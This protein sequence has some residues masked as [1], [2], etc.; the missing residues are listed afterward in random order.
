MTDGLTKIV[1]I[2]DGPS[3]KNAKNNLLTPVWKVMILRFIHD[4]IDADK[5]VD[6]IYGSDIIVRCRRYHQQSYHLHPR[7][8]SKDSDCY[9]R[10]LLEV[11]SA[12]SHKL[13][14][15][16]L[17]LQLLQMSI[18]ESKHSSDD[19]S[20]MA[21]YTSQG[22]WAGDAPNLDFITINGTIDIPARFAEVL[23]ERVFEFKD[24]EIGYQLIFFKDGLIM[25]R[26]DSIEAKRQKVMSD[27][28]QISHKQDNTTKPEDFQKEL[29]NKAEKIVE[30]LKEYLQILNCIYL[31][32]D[33]STLTIIR[34]NWFQVNE[35]T[36]RDAFSV[37]CMNGQMICQLSEG[38]N[39]N[40]FQL[41]RN[42]SSYQGMPVYVDETTK[43]V[44]ILDQRL[45]NRICLPKDVFSTVNTQLR[46]LLK[47]R[48]GNASSLNGIR[49]LSDI[50]KSIHEYKIGNY[51][52]SLVLAWFNIEIFISHKWRELLRS[53]NKSRT[54]E[55]KI[56]QSR[57]K[58]FDG[59]DYTINTVLNIFEHIIL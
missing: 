59:R 8:A 17:S 50:T 54:D 13:I 44:R 11:A 56:T 49:M 6:D 43:V 48:I 16:T 46:L 5:Y 7:G 55:T 29:D 26:L 32:L 53:K 3:S 18:F 51:S 10:K 31:L 30:F 15:Y 47:D 38:L 58:E 25:F 35:L 24:S 33:S 40:S 20:F 23:S 2:M 27:A 45:I 39:Q 42:F 28:H 22:F 21:F 1:D 52:T 36:N 14:N 12:D 19:Q 41:G 34:N 57:L 4:Y 9:V 37:K